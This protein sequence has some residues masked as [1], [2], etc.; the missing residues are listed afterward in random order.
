MVTFPGCKI[1]LGLHILNRRPDGYHDL[2]TC[3][4]PV[5]WTDILELIPSKEYAFALTGLTIPGSPDNNLVAKAYQMLRADFDLAPVQ[6]H[7]H[8]LVPMGAGLGG[9]SADAAHALRLLNTLF[10]LQIPPSKLSEYAQQLGSDCSFFLSGAPAMGSGKG[11]ILEPAE[12]PLNGYYAIILTP[13]IHLSTAEAYA[14]V[15]PKQPVENLRVTLKRPVTEW[16]KWLVNDFEVTVFPRFP[17]LAKLKEHCYI[18]GAVYASMSGSGSSVYAL[19]DR[20][21]LPEELF[22]GIR[23]WSGWL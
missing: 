3:F 19:F 11:E 21:V 12:L 14:S 20:E 10:S 5:P 16:R 8:K 9:G 23:G 2:N 4:F 6:V 15:K 18:K 1:N 22:P 7:L 13:E 17:Q